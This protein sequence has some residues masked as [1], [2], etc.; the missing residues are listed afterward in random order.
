MWYIVAATNDDI[1]LIS[2][3]ITKSTV[4]LHV[5]YNTVKDLMECQ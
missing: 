2:A 5:Y 1:N 3:F 4:K